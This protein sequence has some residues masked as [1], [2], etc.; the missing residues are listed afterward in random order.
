VWF[1]GVV[2][3]TEFTFTAVESWVFG[4]PTAIAAFF[5]VAATGLAVYRPGGVAG[6]LAYGAG[7][8]CAAFAL[9]AWVT[10][11]AISGLVPTPGG[12]EL[13]GIETG[14]GILL[15]F[16]AGVLGGGAGLLE[17]VR[18]PNADAAGAAEVVDGASVPATAEAELDPSA[19]DE[20]WAAAAVA[21]WDDDPD[22]DGW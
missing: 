10:A 8:S 11:D 13:V 4:V 19:S 22:D 6:L 3:R 2:A 16:L 21:R 12:A 17:V 7:L 20:D 18:R 1:T 14:P 15:V 5:L 9:L